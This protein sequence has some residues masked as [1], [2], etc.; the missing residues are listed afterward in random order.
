[1]MNPSSSMIRRKAISATSP[2]SRCQISSITPPANNR[3]AGKRLSPQFKLSFAARVTAG[4]WVFRRKA[5]GDVAALAL[6]GW[7]LLISSGL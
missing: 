1:M 6:V 7:Y 2:A 5:F 3:L 4:C